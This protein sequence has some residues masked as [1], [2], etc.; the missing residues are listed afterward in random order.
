MNINLAAKY[1]IL[2]RISC[3]CYIIW[4]V[5]YEKLKKKKRLW[6]AYIVQCMRFLDSV[7]LLRFEHEFLFF[8]F[9]FAAAKQKTSVVYLIFCFKF[10]F[11]FSS[12][13]ICIISLNFCLILESDRYWSETVTFGFDRF[14]WEVE[15]QRKRER[16][17]R[18][19]WNVNCLKLT[20]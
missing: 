12:R 2:T 15:N 11:P 8:F 14:N 16:G 1:Y 19:I 17:G 3:Y 5:I 6:L 10:F 4:A 7:L 20:F 9:I 13:S 18:E